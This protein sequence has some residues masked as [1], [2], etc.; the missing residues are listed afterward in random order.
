MLNHFKATQQWD[1]LR[2]ILPAYL[3]SPLS[4]PGMAILLRA[5]DVEEFGD[6]APE[7]PYEHTIDKQIELWVGAED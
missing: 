7:R 3:E 5:I 4:Q 6:K 2:R 1:K